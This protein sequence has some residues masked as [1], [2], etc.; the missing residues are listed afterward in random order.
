MFHRLSP[1]NI[2]TLGDQSQ[3][4]NLATCIIYNL[5]RLPLHLP[6][7]VSCST[8]IPRASMDFTLNF[9]F[10]ET[11]SCQDTNVLTSTN[12]PASSIRFSRFFR[13]VIFSNTSFSDRFS[14]FN[15]NRG[16]R[17][18]VLASIWSKKYGEQKNVSALRWIV[19]VFSKSITIVQGFYNLAILCF[20]LTVFF[21]EVPPPLFRKPSS[22]TIP[23][24]SFS[25]LQR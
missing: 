20:S 17:G 24:C 19:W 16:V 13:G 18:C 3:Y 14:F 6:S 5:I 10:R 8:D 21:L 1:A 11:L 23:S 7:Y 12:I 2:G 25:P 22:L 15:S 9:G 4:C